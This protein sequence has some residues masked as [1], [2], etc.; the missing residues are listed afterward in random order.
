MAPFD[1]PRQCLQHHYQQKTNY[2]CRLQKSQKKIKKKEY[3]ES[4]RSEH[5][6]YTEN[7]TLNSKKSSFNIQS[8]EL[9]Y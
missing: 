2:S 3:V 4:P 1:S 9:K 6:L 8:S 5:M 7:L